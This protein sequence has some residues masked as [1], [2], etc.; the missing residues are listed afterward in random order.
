LIGT[1][2]PADIVEGVERNGPSFA[3]SDVMPREALEK[4]SSATELE[5]T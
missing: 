5:V 2:N 1:R 4:F 3:A